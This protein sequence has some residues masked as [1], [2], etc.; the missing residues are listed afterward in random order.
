MRAFLAAVII[1]LLVLTAGCGAGSFP[2]K[3]PQPGAGLTDS[4]VRIDQE[5]AEKVKETAKTVRGVE[6]CAAVV[7]NGEISA[8]VKVKG[9]NR[10][11][12]KSIREEAYQKITESNKGYKVHVTSDKKLFAQLRQMERQIKEGKVQSKSGL[13]KRVQKIIEDMQG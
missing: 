3:K 4:E 6:D 13:H 2:S 9:F 11:R 1:S 12:L 8:A 5:L 10:L 7:I